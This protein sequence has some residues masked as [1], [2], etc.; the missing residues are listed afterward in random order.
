MLFARFSPYLIALFLG[1]GLGILQLVP[2]LLFPLAFSLVLIL[3]LILFVVS[4]QRLWSA[5]FWA[6]LIT[7]FWLLVSS[8]SLIMIVESSF[9]RWLLVLA[10]PCLEALYLR[11]LFLY[12]YQ[13]T[14]YQAYSLE[15]YSVTLNVLVAFFGF[16]S[17][18]GLKL[19]LGLGWSVLVPLCIALVVTIMYQSLWVQKMSNAQGV[20]WLL[21]IGIVLPEIFVSLGFLP[22]SHFVD[23]LIMAILFYLVFRLSRLALDKS[24]ERR[25]I[26]RHVAVSF[27]LII[28]TLVTARWV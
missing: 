18:F 15:N 22:T 4:G 9:V 28:I 21:G 24:F 5:T 1:V 23:G 6:L 12:R 11:Q 10:I 16:S 19:F 7:P 2:N 3:G 20:F 27:T 8:V 13:T 17:L 26:I 14:S 25:L